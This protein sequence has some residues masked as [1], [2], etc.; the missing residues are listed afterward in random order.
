MHSKGV[1]A[2]LRINGIG[3]VLIK[4][5]VVPGKVPSPNPCFSKERFNRWCSPSTPVGHQISRKIQINAHKIHFSD[6]LWSIFGIFFLGGGD[7]WNI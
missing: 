3:Q 4:N 1:G 5:K 2:Y 6:I 7:I